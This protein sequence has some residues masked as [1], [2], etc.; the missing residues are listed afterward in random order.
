MNSLEDEKYQSLS[1]LTPEVVQQSI[2]TLE[3]Q[4]YKLIGVAKPNK[5]EADLLDALSW[6]LVALKGRV[7]NKPLHN[8]VTNKHY[9]PNCTTPVYKSID[10]WICGYCGQK[11]I[12]EDEPN[13]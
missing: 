12:W 1:Q 5:H 13:D 4:K 3:A 7:E 6:G 2:R 9:C 10:R 11:L 8:E